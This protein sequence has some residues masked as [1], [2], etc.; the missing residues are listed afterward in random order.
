MITKASAFIGRKTSGAAGTDDVRARVVVSLCQSRLSVE[1]IAQAFNCSE[2]MVRSLLVRPF[3]SQLSGEGPHPVRSIGPIDLKAML[4]LN[5]AVGLESGPGSSEDA[6][7]EQKEHARLLAI[8]V[9]R[10]L[11][12]FEMTDPDRRYVIEQAGLLL[13]DSKLNS[14]GKYDFDIDRT[15]LDALGIWGPKAFLTGDREFRSLLGRWLAS[16]I[17][18]WITDPVVWNRALDLA[19]ASFEE[20]AQAA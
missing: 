7:C 14:A 11:C 2:S 19:F 4:Q 13:D 15:V 3:R 18:F 1:D 9:R 5:R 17:R 12:T 6:A 8:E 16:W 10:W 20:N